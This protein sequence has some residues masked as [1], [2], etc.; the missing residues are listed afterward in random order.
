MLCAATPVNEDVH[1]PI[2]VEIGNA[3]PAHDPLVR[4]RNRK[5]VRIVREEIESATKRNVGEVKSGL[6]MRGPCDEHGDEPGDEHGDE[7]G[8]EG[9]DRQGDPNRH[10]N[11]R[12][13][14]VERLALVFTVVFNMGHTSRAVID[15]HV[16]EYRPFRRRIEILELIISRRPDERSQRSTV[17]PL[18]GMSTAATRGFTSPAKASAHPSALYPTETAK[19]TRIAR[20]VLREPTRNL[21]SGRSPRAAKQTSATWCEACAPLRCRTRSPHTNDA[22]FAEE[23]FRKN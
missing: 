10:R 13:A 5:R 19:F 4:T 23:A 17:N 21:S 20:M 14:G 22:P 9:G 2:A 16:I 3:N 12:S 1:Q 11:F 15:L 8:D 18:N 7:G 6:A